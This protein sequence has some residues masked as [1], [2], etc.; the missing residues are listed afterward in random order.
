MVFFK[1]SAYLWTG[2]LSIAH[3]QN[4]FYSNSHLSPIRIYLNPSFLG[5][6]IFMRI[7]KNGFK[8]GM[9][10]REFLGEEPFF[11]GT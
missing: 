2:S 10:M 1:L 11:R 4:P 3:L 8:I 9:R 7:L 6:G 5:M